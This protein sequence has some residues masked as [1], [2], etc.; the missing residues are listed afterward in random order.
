VAYWLNKVKT[1]WYESDYLDLVLGV[2]LILPPLI[3]DSPSRHYN[4]SIALLQL[5]FVVVFAIRY[6]RHC[7]DFSAIDKRLLAVFFLFTVW[8]FFTVLFAVHQRYAFNRNFSVF[9]YIVFGYTV[10]RYFVLRE[11]KRIY[12]AYL[13][14]FSFLGPAIGL[15]IYSL[16]LDAP[17][18]TD[19]Y[20]PP[21]YSNIRHMGY[22]V[23]ASLIF[24]LLVFSRAAPGLHKGAAGIWVLVTVAYL[25]LAGGRG[26]I[27]ALVIGAVVLLLV[28]PHLRTRLTMLIISG[29]IVLIAGLLF[30]NIELLGYGMIRR[31]LAATSLDALLGHRM[32]LW[33]STFPHIDNWWLGI[34]ADNFFR[35]EESGR[36]TQA[37][38]VVL[39]AIF[40][41]GVIGTLGFMIL[42]L[43]TVAGAIG[44]VRRPQMDDHM[45]IAAA[46]LLVSYLALSMIDGVFYHAVP[47][48]LF[49]VAG[50]L[51]FSSAREQSRD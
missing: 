4:Y 16:T 27:V 25:V 44:R 40:D 9:L 51:A 39:Q 43:A 15:F 22:H 6:G 42:V 14:S 26:P 28:C 19:F 29:T 12:V 32:S 34:G 13:M 36:Y 10:W 7:A 49:V 47:F 33:S 18:Y 30:F 5:I 45:S 38:N 50:A 8:M 17:T 37:H 23:A 3:H 2:V 48:T 46:G 24:A 21:F 35:L 11:G 31:T 1:F 41:W 20:N